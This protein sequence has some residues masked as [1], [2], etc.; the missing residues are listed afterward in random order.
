M[1]K[2]TPVYLEG[3]VH[4]WVYYKDKSLTYPAVGVMEDNLIR[5][6][7]LKPSNPVMRGDEIGKTV[8]KLIESKGQAPL[9]TIKLEDNR[10][11]VIA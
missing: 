7:L 4:L 9:G 5:L 2:R 10:G 1:S 11:E 3:D 6:Q 8:A